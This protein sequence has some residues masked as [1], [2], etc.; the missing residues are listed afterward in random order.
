[1]ASTRRTSLLAALAATAVLFALP[2][3]AGANVYCVDVSGGD[4]THL[5][6][7]GDLQGGL[8]DAA[9]NAGPDTVRLGAT[10]YPATSSAG[11]SYFSNTGPVSIIGSGQGTTTIAVQA[12]GAP[13]GSFTQFL[14]LNVFG[15][16][17]AGSSITDLTVS[18]PIPAGSSENQQYRGVQL[19]SGT[20]SEVTV[21]GP[22]ADPMGA[23]G[24]ILNSGTLENSTVTLSR[25]GS[26]GTT[27]VANSNNGDDDISLVHNSITADTPVTYGNTG[28]GVATVSRS[29]LLPSSAGVRTLIGSTHVED[30]IIDLGSFTNAVGISTGFSNPTAHVSASTADGVTI[31]GTGT[32]A[33][34]IRAIAN[35][36]NV[37]PTAGDIA[38]ATVASSILDQSLDV[39]IRRQADNNGAANVS[40]DYS[41]Y[42]AMANVSTNG[43]NGGTGQIT[44]TNQT[45][46]TPEFVG[47]GDFH[48]LSSSPL[49]DIGDP[50]HPAPGRLDIDGDTR[51]ILGE[52]GCGP[53]RDIGADEFDPPSPPAMLA[54]PPETSIISGPS[55]PTLDSTPTFEFESSE[56][57]STF[58]CKIDN[59]A[60]D[61]CTSPFTSAL[62]L[63][64]PH[65]FSVKAIDADLNEDPSP[66]SQSFTVDTVAPDTTILSGPTGPTS[67]TT[68]TFTFESTESPA[69][70]K[71]K[72][73][74]GL[75]FACPASGFTTGTLLDGPHT[76]EV[77]AIDAA[78]NEDPSPD[79]QSFTV[80]TA[81][82]D[83]TILSGPSGPTSDATP[84]FSF[85]SSEP[86]STFQ[87]SID[88]AGFAACGSPFTT[89][90][91]GDGAHSIA[92]KAIDSASN[93]DASPATRSFSIDATA[94]DT[95]VSGKAKV[96]TRKKK[97]RISW[98]LG[99]T[100]PGATI[101]C[102]LDGGGFVPCVSPF[103]A[104]LRR[105]AH[106]LVARARDAL[107]NVDASPASFT[108]KVKRKR[109]RR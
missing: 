107:G 1:M 36:L 79:S 101:E 52:D 90:A 84:T 89:A 65:T 38:S 70:F 55:G 82:P 59:G 83:T 37:V 9:A 24:I 20:I 44:A 46:V 29:T 58:M 108:T 47:G 51:E 53:R 93:E 100:D 3:S 64:G 68:P 81:A 27:G 42:N 25:V 2:S 49:I 91:L 85:D 21:A 41:N 109:V 72:I 77:E 96:K 74:S 23:F 73:D 14:G 32:G 34:G 18:L 103:T 33:T 13:P 87:C 5:E 22:T 97:V 105:G 99:T 71:C 39:P 30:T 95:S 63:D 62:L 86:G 76:F 31:A 92:V 4:C 54:C 104:K 88:G 15:S 16:G 10:T 45:N 48:L 35:D 61:D 66:D 7:A 80:D 69:T 94:P 50:A 8:N 19:Q 56:A 102:S 106:T 11:F 98:I 78:L 40:T 12:P 67:D 60:F 6:P 43:V 28:T 26:P 75:F 17:A 57:S